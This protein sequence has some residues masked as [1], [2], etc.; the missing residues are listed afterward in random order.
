MEEWFDAKDKLPSED[1]ELLVCQIKVVQDA[2]F[3]DGCFYCEGQ[4]GAS[5]LPSLPSMIYPDENV[6]WCYA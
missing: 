1:K 5:A 4:N 2:V 6:S 3:K